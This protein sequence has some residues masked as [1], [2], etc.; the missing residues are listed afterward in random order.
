MIDELELHHRVPGIDSHGT[1]G[2]DLQTVGNPFGAGDDGFRRAVALDHANS[3]IPSDGESWVVTETGDLDPM[4]LGRLHDGHTS[5]ILYFLAIEL[6]ACHLGF[7]FS[8]EKPLLPL[9]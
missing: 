3:A 1:L 5:W 2:F 6:P 8:H 4:F 7:Q 9:L